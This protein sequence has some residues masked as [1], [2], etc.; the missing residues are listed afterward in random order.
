MMDTEFMQRFL[1]HSFPRRRENDTLATFR[2]AE[3][4]LRNITEYGLLLTPEL[5]TWVEQEPYPG[6]AR[7]FSYVQRRICLTEL[8]RSELPK[9][10]T[11]FGEYAIEFDMAAAREL[12]AIP[13]FYIPAST[14]AA[15][16]NAIGATMMHR[17]GEIRDLLASLEQ[18]L[19]FD[20]HSGDV[21]LLKNE[22]PVECSVRAARAFVRSLFEERVSP[23]GLGNFLDA[24]LGHFYPT[25]N[26]EHNEPLGY[27]QQ[28]EWRISGRLT[29]DHIPAVGDSPGELKRKLLE[30][31]KGFFGTMIQFQ[32]DFRSVADWSLVFRE[33]SGRHV[34][35]YASSVICPRE[36][37]T[38][39]KRVLSEKGL[40]LEVLP[41][42]AVE[43]Q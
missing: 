9:H 4:I 6:Q 28:R 43:K 27:Y 39:V 14:Q 11:F 19:A 40:S 5:V 20:D 31:D 33:V 42:E 12:G 21:P 13:V 37:A 36:R 16:F 18:V 1:Y 29:K 35:T 22:R 34:L 24:L 30:L 7:N 25:E 26:L 8:S 2:K 10:A 3:T 23:R 32:G 41:I 17:L 15:G 38:H